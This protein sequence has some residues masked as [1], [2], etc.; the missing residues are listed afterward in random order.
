MRVAIIPARGGS[1]RIPRKN[2][3]LFC[4]E[5]MLSYSIAAARASGL[6]D[7]I[8]VSTDDDEIAK[9]AKHC[10]AEVP[11]MRPAALADDHCVIADVI[12]HAVEWCDSALLPVESVCCLYATAPLVAAS[13][14]LR[15]YTVFNQ[16]DTRWVLAVTSFPFPIQR[17]L[18]VNAEDCFAMIVPENQTV[19]SQDLEDTYHDAGQFFWQSRSMALQQDHSGTLGKNRAV[20]IPRFRVQDIDTEEDWLNAELM[21]KVLM[22]RELYAEKPQLP[23]KPIYQE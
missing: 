17:A 21:Q 4:G 15:G 10:G 2:I 13:D 7:K 18:R 8:I 22:Q 9:I 6:F 5:P 20:V 23:K 11:F 14:I 19:R 1:K 12:K 3:K 16:P